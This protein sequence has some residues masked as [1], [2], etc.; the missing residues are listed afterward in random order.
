MGFFG[1]SKEEKLLEA[2]SFGDLLKVKELVK[3]R[4]N[5]NAANEVHKQPRAILEVSLLA[6]ATS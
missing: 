2:S 5:V 1:K 3:S 6:H 4:A